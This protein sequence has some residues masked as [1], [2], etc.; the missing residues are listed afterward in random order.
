MIRRMYA[1]PHHLSSIVAAFLL[2]FPAL[3]SIVN[4]LS[5]ALI[6][7]HVMEER[8]LAE[9]NRLARRVGFYSLIVLLVSLW[10]GAYVLNFFGISLGALRLAGGLVVAVR[11][12]S[13]LNAP[14]EHEARKEQQAAPA[15]DAEDV[16]FFP[17]TLPFTTGP[18]SIAVAIAL[19]STRPRAGEPGQWTFL[20]GVTAAA[21]AMAACVWI[22]YSSASRLVAL[23]GRDG[24]RVVNRLAAF[25]LL[26]IGVQIAVS[27]VQDVLTPIIHGAVSSR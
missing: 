15:G 8:G 26:C 18:G 17:L 3:F 11:A 7:N 27:G 21:V 24:A 2:A 6:F 25:L 23:L 10:G 22:F 1:D 5:G 13:L 9:R 4:P 19:G 14:E 16:A 12:W 20:L